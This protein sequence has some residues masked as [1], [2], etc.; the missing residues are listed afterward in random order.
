VRINLG[1]GNRLIIEDTVLT[2]LSAAQFIVTDEIKGPSSS[3]T[4][5]LVSTADNVYIESLLTTGDAIGGYKASSSRSPW[6]R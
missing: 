3:Q 4:P 2:D 6:Q 1:G 5:Y